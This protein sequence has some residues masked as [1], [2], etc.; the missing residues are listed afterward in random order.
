MDIL[1]KKLESLVGFGSTFKKDKNRT[2]PW[3]CKL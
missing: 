1:Y 3:R 2:C